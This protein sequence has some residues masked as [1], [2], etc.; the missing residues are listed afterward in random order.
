MSKSNQILANP[1]KPH[2][3]WTIGAFRIC[4]RKKQTPIHI[5]YE[6]MTIPFLLNGAI[7]S[8]FV[9]Y[10]KACNSEFINESFS[11]FSRKFYCLNG[12]LDL[13]TTKQ[14][15]ATNINSLINM[16]K[17][18]RQRFSIKENV[19]FVCLLRPRVN[20]VIVKSNN[21]YLILT[22]FYKNVPQR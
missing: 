12:N 4:F 3:C 2:L 14:I 9:P 5:V 7:F 1:L 6:A 10:V 18:S 17:I 19:S 22:L 8:L 21:Y 20:Q 13:E 11:L 15:P 16:M